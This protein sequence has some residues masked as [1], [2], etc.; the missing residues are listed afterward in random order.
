MKRDYIKEAEKGEWGMFFV[1]MAIFAAIA[2]YAWNN[3]PGWL[4][5]AKTT[6]QQIEAKYEKPATPIDPQTMKDMQALV[7][8]LVLEIES[9]KAGNKEEHRELLEY[10]KIGEL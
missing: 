9:I 5:T 7:G 2:W 4:E 1:W 8:E 3:V 10:Y 6:A